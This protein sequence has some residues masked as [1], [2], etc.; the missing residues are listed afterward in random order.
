M[1]D[2]QTGFIGALSV[3]VT[4]ISTI[5]VARFTDRFRRHI[6]L[7]VMV[8]GGFA[9]ACFV[10]LTLIVLQTIPFQMWQ[11]Y[12][13]VF[14]GV[15]ALYTCMPLLLEYT[16]EMTYPVPEGIVGGFL[17]FGYNIVSVLSTNCRNTA[18]RSV[19]TFECSNVF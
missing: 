4:A 18:T 14:V 11:L 5:V 10:W 17:T 1:D 8:L 3:G 6:K 19:N 12:V 16:N 9:T 2:A 13:S 15:S 7:T